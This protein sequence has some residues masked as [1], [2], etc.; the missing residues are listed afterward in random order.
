M[1]PTRPRRRLVVAVCPREPGTVVLP[2]VPGG[3]R[4]RMD[5]AQVA[6]HLQALADARGLGGVVEVRPACAGGCLGP[7]PNVSVTI[8]PRARPGQ[9]PDRVAV[10][11]RTYVTS[12]GALGSLSEILDDNLG[13]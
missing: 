12:L 1:S 11:W 3:R 6:R 8:Y 5:A 13:G 10:A 4:L 9:R 7:G 2:L